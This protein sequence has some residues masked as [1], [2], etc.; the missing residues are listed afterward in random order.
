MIGC[1]LDRP[2][3][4]LPD[5]GQGMC[6]M[7]AAVY[8]PGRCTCWVPVYDLEQQEIVPGLPLPPIPVRMCG[9]CAYRPH[10]PERS[11]GEGY[12]GDAGTLDDLVRNRE[13][14]YCHQ[15][16]RKPVSHR[17]P[18]AYDPPI[19][20]GVPYKAD[21]TPANLCAGWLLRCA[22]EATS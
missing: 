2:A 21:G 22:K 5:A 17:H 12:N 14:F 13:P 9:D 8:G 15:G 18:A 11:G 1:G 16:I 7:G 19:R 3:P 4:G 20:D 10:S 6:C